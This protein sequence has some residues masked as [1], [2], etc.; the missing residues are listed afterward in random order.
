MPVRGPDRGRAAAGAAPVPGAA[1]V[2]RRL[3]FH[4]L[5]QVELT[6]TVSRVRAAEIVEQ[7]ELVQRSDSVQM[8]EAVLEL[9]D[10]VRHVA[11]G[12]CV[13]ITDVRAVEVDPSVPPAPGPPVYPAPGGHV[14]VRVPG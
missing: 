13:A 1:V 2:K 4:M 9:D 14:T 6:A 10:P 7:R 12:A 11:L 3:T 8:P 5:G